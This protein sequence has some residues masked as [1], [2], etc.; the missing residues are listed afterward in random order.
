ME[1]ASDVAELGTVL[2]AASRAADVLATTAPDERAGWLDDVATALDEASDRLVPL[3]D[4]ETH[5]GTARL[6]ES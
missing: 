4:D 1:E 3:A 6:T 2:D 5:L